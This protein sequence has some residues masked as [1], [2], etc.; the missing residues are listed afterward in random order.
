LGAGE[1]GGQARWSRAGGVGCA[2]QERAGVCGAAERKR[3]GKRGRRWR[4]VLMQGWRVAHWGLSELGGREVGKS[5]G[6]S[7]TAMLRQA[8]R[9]RHT[10]E[11]QTSGPALAGL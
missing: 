3:A 2:R 4:D 5:R 1:S 8:E 10:F 7:E 6:G 9:S 11:M